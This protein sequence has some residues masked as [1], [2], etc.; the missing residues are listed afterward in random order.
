MNP[1]E[2]RMLILWLGLL[3]S[4][5]LFGQP[6]PRNSASVVYHPEL[7]GVLVYGG[8]THSRSSSQLRDSV[9]WL[10]NGVRWKPYTT[11]PSIRMN[12][13]LTYHA[14]QR[15]LILVGG[16][17]NY[18]REQRRRYNDTW[19]FDGTQWKQ[20]SNPSLP[21][22]LFH[23]A[24]AYHPQAGAV[25]LFGGYDVSADQLSQQTWTYQQGSWTLQPNEPGPPP[26][27][28]HCLFT[29]PKHG[30][31]VVAGGDN[32]TPEGLRDMWLLQ[33]D[34]WQ[35]LAGDMPF[36]LMG[37][38]SATAIGESGDYFFFNSS[39]HDQVSEVWLWRGASQTWEK[40]SAPAPAPRNGAAI[41]YDAG[42]HCIMVFGG[43]M[44]WE[45]TNE[46][47]EFSLTT[48]TWI[49]AFPK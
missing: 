8:A 15:K 10:W 9:V 48:Q 24:G 13:I 33:G 6:A 21:G 26:R 5:N 30:G 14:A 49:K 29:D 12:A 20:T 34:R 27:N 40:I 3:T 4:M 42:R 32:M 16:A 41:A 23:T 17:F 43:E 2:M 28:L 36:K 38:Y 7:R 22:H 45:S 18:S 47:W 1:K 35:Q 37:Q 11:A 44:G 19:E 46:V 31:V 25:T 39:S